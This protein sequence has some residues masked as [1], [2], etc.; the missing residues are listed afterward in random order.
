MELYFEEDDFDGFIAK[1]GRRNDIQYIGDRC[2]R[3]RMGTAHSA[4]LIWTATSLSWGEHENGCEAVY[5]FQ[6]AH[7]GDFQTNGMSLYLIWK[8]AAE[9]NESLGECIMPLSVCGPWSKKDIHGRRFYE[10]GTMDELL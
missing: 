4:F 3:S 5:P 7:G 8:T 1:L 6:D 10:L 9:L 2:E